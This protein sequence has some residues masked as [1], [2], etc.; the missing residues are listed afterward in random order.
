MSEFSCRNMHE[1]MMK[2]GKCTYVYHTGETCGKR[3]YFT[4]G[5]TSAEMDHV[6]EPV[7][8]DEDGTEEEE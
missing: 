8:E 2:D 6:P 5:M 3:V 7:E 4:D 1:N